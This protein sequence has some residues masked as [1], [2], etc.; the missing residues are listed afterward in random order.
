[1]LCRNGC[2]KAVVAGYTNEIEGDATG[3]EPMNISFANRP[4][5]ENKSGVEEESMME[6]EE[7]QQI[8]HLRPVGLTIPVEVS[9]S[10]AF[11]Q[12]SKHRSRLF[13]RIG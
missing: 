13:G 8:F 11:W 9:R 4:W 12:T 5:G 6:S 7:G 2:V 10:I 3:D 1:M